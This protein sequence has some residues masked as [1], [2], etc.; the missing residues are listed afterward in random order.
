MD[1]G[2]V[3]KIGLDR[4]AVEVSF[5]AHGVERSQPILLPENYL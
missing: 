4:N 3:F 2:R 1:G 5:I